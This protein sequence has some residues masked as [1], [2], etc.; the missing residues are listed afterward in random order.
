[1]KLPV[2]FFLFLL[3]AALGPS[4][5]RADTFDPDE[6]Q[7]EIQAR[8]YWHYA[9][10]LSAQVRGDS[11]RALAE[12][13]QAARVDSDS[14]AVHNR[15]AYHYYQS[16]LDAK[17]E[18]ELRK[19]IEIDPS[20]IDNRLLLA[21]LL[22]SQEEYGKAQNQYEA[23]LQMDPKNMEA[24]Y[25]LAGILAAQNRYEDALEKYLDIL[26]D[27]PKAAGI[28]YNIGLL[29]V[30][31]NESSQA[32]AAFQKA[33]QMDPSL[34]EAYNSLGLVYE[35]DQ[36]PAQALDTYAALIKIKPDDAPAYEAMGELYYNAN[37]DDKAIDAFQNYAKLKPDDPSIQDYIGVCSYRLKDYPAAVLAFQKLLDAQPANDLVRYR[38]AATDE[39]A[40]LDDDAV[41]QLGT[42]LAH[43]PK[44]TDAWDQTVLVYH[45]QKKMDLAQQTLAAGL[46]A[47]PGSEDL[48]LL[49][50]NLSDEQGDTKSAEAGYRKVLV[51]DPKNSQAAYDLGALLD[52]EGHFAEAMEQMKKVIQ[53]Q[54][55]NAEAFNYIGYSYA[56]KNQ[57]L[58]EAQKDVEQALKLDPGNA[59]YLDSLGWVFYRKNQF[60]T[61]KEKLELAIQELGPSAAQAQKDDAIIFDHL[62]HVFLKLGDKAGAQ[63]QLKK[64][65]Q[66]DPTNKDFIN[67][68]SKLD[69]TNSL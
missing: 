32:E 29:Y 65:L 11:D 22:S 27:N 26:K 8:A 19:S 28:Y 68:Q 13:E 14:S 24:R 21:S 63:D 45:K 17:S 41:S 39:E 61:A 33:I 49:Q 44:N 6:S 62:A 67:D 35:L 56:D 47:N 15:L 50:A 54:P 42:I 30:R 12:F 38:L 46:K 23:I 53:L 7:L 55:D 2:L 25:Y 59:Y 31:M 16:G 1:M 20:N 10:G 5:S 9:C 60:S 40:G 3:S 48:L 4:F 43:D 66:L 34:V 64:A 18:E 57:N 58:D 52:Q 69:T 37:Q 51:L 36:K